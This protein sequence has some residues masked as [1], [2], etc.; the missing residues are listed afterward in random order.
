MSS[1]RPRFA[2]PPSAAGL[3]LAGLF[4]A[5]S[6]TP[7]LVPRSF[8]LQGA[9]SGLSLAAGYGVGAFGCWL[10]SF[11][12]LPI[13]RGRAKRALVAALAV[14]TLALGASFLAR[15]RGWQ[16]S[17]RELMGLEP[18]GSAHP[19]RV[20]AIAL[21]VLVAALVV[22]RL[23]LLVLRA[24]SSRL[25]PFVPRRIAGVVGVAV[26]AALFWSVVDGV[27]LR[28]ALRAMDVSFQKVDALLEPEVPKPAGAAK[29]GSAASVVAWEDLGRRGREFVSSGPTAGDL[30]AFLGGEAKEPVRVYVGLGSAGSIEER[31]R[32]ALAE[33]ERVG[34]F[35]RSVLVVVT[36]TGTG[37]VDPG[38][39]DAVEYL[40][41]GDLASVAVQY[42]YLPSWLTLL[43]EAEYGAE[44]AKALFRAVYARWTSLPRDRR[45]KLY[46]FGL[47]L[48]ALNSQRSAD[49][50]DV[51]GDPFSGALWVGPPFRSE[52]WRDFTAQRNPGSP[53]WRPLFR[54][55]AIVRFANQQGGLDVPGARWGPL[56]IVYLQYASD[57][58]TF[59]EPRALFRAPEWMI[60]PRG[61]DVSEH[62]RFFPVVTMLQLAVDIAVADRTPV[63]YG[64]VYAP[65]HYADAWRAATDPPGWTDEEI[66]R[67]KAHLRR[68]R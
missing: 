21:A 6:L 59:F 37:W 47:S 68:G 41:R 13:L 48:G 7:S 8:V 42:S 62:L 19:L 17:V 2:A 35:E 67:L 54:D 31:V 32:L 24:V 44:T 50:Y 28:L 12:E 65:E 46:L 26:A 51:L 53:A 16:N 34:A 43:T 9:L 1:T 18:V 63:G 58:I 60:P 14:P 45:P 40:H 3:L 23:F 20:A 22:A 64:H 66:A 15:S 36:P 30:R 52:L 49:V 57:P 25:R 56:R 55:G 11:L 39:L 38:A 5:A 33:L 29:T 27:L 4:F 61:P 10:W